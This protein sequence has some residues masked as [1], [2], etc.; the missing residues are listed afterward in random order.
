MTR[1]LIGLLGGCIIGLA[2]PAVAMS[3][4]AERLDGWSVWDGR[5]LLCKNPVVRHGV[6]EIRCQ[7]SDTAG[8]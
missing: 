5:V 6:N 7:A 8:D 3:T 2:A 4:F 1:F